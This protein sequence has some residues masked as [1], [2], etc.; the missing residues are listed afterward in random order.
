MQILTDLS[1]DL[2]VRVLQHSWARISFPVMLDQVPT[3]LHH[4]VA[5]TIFPPASSER[6]L[7]INCRLYDLDALAVLLQAPHTRTL[8]RGVSIS[9]FIHQYSASAPL[10]NALDLRDSAKYSTLQ[11]CSTNITFQK[12]PL[13]LV[14]AAIHIQQPARKNSAAQDQKHS[15]ET[16]WE[17][18]ATHSSLT[19]LKISTTGSVQDTLSSALRQIVKLTGLKSLSVL[20][21]STQY[22]VPAALSALTQLTRLYLVCGDDLH[23][24]LLWC[25]CSL[26]NLRVLH[27]HP[28]LGGEEDLED[29]ECTEEFEYS[30]TSALDDDSQQLSSLTGASEA[31]RACMSGPLAALRALR[32]SSPQLSACSSYLQH[33]R[34]L[35]DLCITYID[36]A[37]TQAVCS[38]LTGLTSLKTCALYVKTEQIKHISE[39]LEASS[40]IGSCT[41]LVA[42]APRAEWARCTDICRSLQAFTNLQHLS[43]IGSGLTLCNEKAVLDAFVQ[44]MKHLTFLEH[45]V[46]NS[47]GAEFPE[48]ILEF[49]TSLRHI[50]PSSSVLREQHPHL[51]LASVADLTTLQHLLLECPPCENLARIPAA[52]TQLTHLHLILQGGKEVSPA[53]CHAT[54]S[55]LTCLSNLH[56]LAMQDTTSYSV[57]SL[58]PILQRLQALRSLQIMGFSSS[59]ILKG[60]GRRKELTKLVLWGGIFKGNWSPPLARS[61]KGLTDLRALKLSCRRGG[62]GMWARDVFKSLSMLQKMSE[63]ELACDWEGSQ[64]LVPSIRSLGLL[65]KLSVSFSESNVRVS[66]PKLLCDALLSLPKL[67]S[68]ELEPV[69]RDSLP[70]S[71]IDRFALDC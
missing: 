56:T 24:F 71:L 22:S 3:D 47:P 25:L 30:A 38:F 14:H 61:L 9:G 31:S 13:P 11:C 33:L 36:P 45:R 55:A 42:N 19:S 59:V 7:K 58:L 34:S 43:C 57:D 65:Q 28:P 6:L 8:Y 1:Q 17:V 26:S 50:N 5:L 23:Q 20:A 10:L 60:I 32:L 69:C 40:T 54:V 66:V 44:S 49:A 63:L 35:K 16:F 53:L 18:L 48:A 21:S 41:K 64:A 2:A 4:L 29:F 12:R 51:W 37:H 68:L 27:L 52:L 15:D 39:S 62:N 70:S 46:Q 67:T